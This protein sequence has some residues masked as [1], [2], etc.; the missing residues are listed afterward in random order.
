MLLL[1]EGPR[2]RAQTEMYDHPVLHAPLL[3][4]SAPHPEGGLEEEC[5]GARFPAE[6]P[7]TVL[8]ALEEWMFVGKEQELM[9]STYCC[10]LLRRSVTVA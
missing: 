10:L 7:P 4:L 2:L 3:S 9:I 1:A 6:S 5:A 8:R